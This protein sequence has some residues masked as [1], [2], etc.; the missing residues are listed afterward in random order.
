VVTDVSEKLNAFIAGM[1]MLLVLK[2]EAAGSSETLLNPYQ[3]L[4]YHKPEDLENVEFEI[5][6]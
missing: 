6:N 3:S 4:R 2:M 1:G 5:F